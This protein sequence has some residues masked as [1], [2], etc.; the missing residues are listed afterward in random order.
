MYPPSSV[1]AYRVSG[2]STSTGRP[3]AG[4]LADVEPGHARQLRREAQGSSPETSTA[5]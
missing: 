1:F 3:E 4:R 2:T 5:V